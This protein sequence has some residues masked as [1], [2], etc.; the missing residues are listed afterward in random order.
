MDL[1]RKIDLTV[2]GSFLATAIAGEI[3]QMATRVGI[4]DYTWLAGH[5]SDITY[6]SALGLLFNITK[7]EIKLPFYASLFTV[8]EITE[9]TRPGCTYDPQDIACIWAGAVV[10]YCISEISQKRCEQKQ[11]M[12]KE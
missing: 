1:E 6:P 12:E 8:M 10:A 5:L 4:L 11:P 7:R 2:G 9:K 3:Y